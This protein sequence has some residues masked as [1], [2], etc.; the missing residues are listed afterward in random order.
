MVALS[1]IGDLQ[2]LVARGAVPIRSAPRSETHSTAPKS[3]DTNF[4]V[5][6]DGTYYPR[7]TASFTSKNSSLSKANDG[8]Y[9][10]LL[11]PPNRWTCEGS[12]SDEDWIDVDFGIAR[13][14]HS[15]KLFVLDDAKLVDGK[16]RAPRA[17]RLDQFVDGEWSKIDCQQSNS[18][19]EGHRPLVLSFPALSISRLRVTLEH[20]EGF[21][22]GLTE[23]EAWGPAQLP[24]DTLPHPIGNLAYNDGSKEFPKATASYHDRFG[25]VPKSAIDG[26]NQFSTL[27]DQSLDEL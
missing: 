22:S 4:A 6:N 10:Y 19:I 8:N 1:R 3:T 18:V 27:P 9:W 20:A 16:V 13:T 14:I 5:N 7:M 2:P 23:L 26:K 24:L 12:P 11:H 17:V 21:K 15:V 25:G